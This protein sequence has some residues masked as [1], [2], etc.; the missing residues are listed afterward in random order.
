MSAADGSG[1]NIYTRDRAQFRRMLVDSVRLHRR[2][3]REWPRL[4]AQYRRALPDL[5]SEAQWRATFEERS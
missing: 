3:Q 4:S 1:K 5:V 2:L